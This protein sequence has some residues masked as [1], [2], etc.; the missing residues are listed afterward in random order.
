MFKK[1]KRILAL[2]MTSVLF[3]PTVSCKEESDKSK[4]SKTLAEKIC[5]EAQ[6][7]AD[8]ARDQK[9]TYGN[10]SI[11]PGYNWGALDVEKAINLDERLSSCDRFVDW[12][13]YRCGFVEQPYDNGYDVPKVYAWFD[14]M[15]FEKITDVSSLQAGDVV[16]T[17]EDPLKPGYP[18]HVF[19]CASENLGDNVYLRYDH[20]ST[21]R[22]RCV[23]GTEV[24]PGQQ[25]F[26]EVI[27]EFYF[28]YRPNDK[29][30]NI[31]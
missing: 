29:L 3:V 30:L 5:E 18:G 11:N 12:V 1:L 4:K 16:F 7:V 10:A 19:I 17:K 14:A 9:F 6:K 25:P 27:D 22:I 26:K 24:T 23:K 31:D 21:E 8:F 28:A 13:L 15:N 2:T 20:G